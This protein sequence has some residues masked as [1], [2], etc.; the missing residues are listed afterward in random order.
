VASTLSFPEIAGP[1]PF[2]DG[3][4]SAETSLKVLRHR[5]ADIPAITGAT[6]ADAALQIAGI[7]VAA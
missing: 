6:L 1:E 4:Q 3:R 5:D 7:G 2:L